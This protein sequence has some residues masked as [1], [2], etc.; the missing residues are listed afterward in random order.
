MS[1]LG[2]VAGW[3][4]PP[5]W[6]RCTL[7]GD[8]HLHRIAELRHTIHGAGHP[9]ALALDLSE[10][11]TIDAPAFSALVS[12]LLRLSAGGTRVAVYGAPPEVARYLHVMGVA[13]HFEVFPTAEHLTPRFR[14]Q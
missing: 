13:R 7:S 8:I 6:V 2:P 9:A 5:G 1:G 3:E 14:D 11:T 10:V 4:S 12:E